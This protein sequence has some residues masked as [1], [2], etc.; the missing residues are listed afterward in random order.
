MTERKDM[1]NVIT[2]PIPVNPFQQLK[3]W[4]TNGKSY[5]RITAIYACPPIPQPSLDLS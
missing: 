3:P 1:N 4:P 5:L 2:Q